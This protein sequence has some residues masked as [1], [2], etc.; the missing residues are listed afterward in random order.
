MKLKKKKSKL[1]KSQSLRVNNL[2]SNDEIEEK[3]IN[4]IKKIQEKKFELT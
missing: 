4:L 2:M 1:K 3:K